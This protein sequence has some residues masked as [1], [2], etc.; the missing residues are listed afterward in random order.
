VSHM[1]RTCLK[2]NDLA[3]SWRR[4]AEALR[5]PPLEPFSMWIERTVRVPEGLSA[6]PGKVTLWP[7][8]VEI[9]NSIGDA[10]V[11]RVT[12]LKAVRS[13]FTFLLAC[14]VARHVRDDAAP[15]IVLMPTE[16]DA[17]GIMVDDLEPLF[18]SSPDLSGLLPEPARDERGRSTLMQRF[19]PGGSIKV[20]SSKAPRNLRRHTARCVYADEV[21]AME[22]VEGDPLK[23]AERRTLTYR[24]RKLVAG[25]S[26]KVED[27]SLICKLYAESDQRVFEIACPQCDHRFE[28]RWA[29]IEW[30]EGKPEK[31]HAVCPE[32]GSV[33]E[34]GDEKARAVAAGRWRATRPEVEGHHGYR[35]N[36]LVSLLPN[37][38][39]GKLA[40]EFV[41]AKDDS[42]LLRAFTTTILA[43]PW[44]EAADDVDDASLAARAE[45]FDLESIPS[46]VLAVTVGCD[47]A[48][49]RIEASIVGHAKNGDA[50]V[51]DH[52]ILYGSPADQRD[53]VWGE[54]DELLRTRRKHPAGGVLKVDAAC[55]DGGDGEHLDAVLAF[56]TPR[57]RHRVFCTKGIFG[58]GRP[59]IARSRGKQRALFILGSDTLKGQIINRLAKGRTI[60][61]SNTLDENYFLQLCSERRIV[62]MSRGRP[63]VRF[64]RRPG[65]MAEALDCL[66]LALGAKAALRLDLDTREAELASVQPP[67][68]REP[69]IARSEFMQRG[70]L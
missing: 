7:P 34:E 5:P 46:E 20:I 65:M 11:E 47:L 54:L 25:S 18:A 63:V 57:L 21:D 69:M 35:L 12:V 36:A 62:R 37:C 51:L 6:E 70:R 31:A 29:N 2:S 16:N 28:L 4:A 45:A 22:C 42:D 41:V 1:L 68:P 8:Q 53:P 15:I 61:F 56:C 32:C 24:N 10:A 43:E 26:P 59:S 38:A 14:A 30:P 27:T 58:P 49:D 19:Y 67:A 55:I 50:L 64:E 60:R 39:W 13:G 44:R 3:L 17:R 52:V 33:I 40:R 9:A 48:D 23:L 66:A